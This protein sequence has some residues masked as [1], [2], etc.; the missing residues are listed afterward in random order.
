MTKIKDIVSINSQAVLSNAI[1]L[2]WYN[3]QQQKSENDRLVAGYVFG[4]GI[5]KKVGS[6]TEI[7]SLP[8]FETIRDTFGN[9][10]ASNIITVIAKYG[11]GKSHFALVLA[12][13]FGLPPASPVV[14]EIISHIEICSNK[15]TADQFRHFKNQTQK[16]QLVVTLVGHQFQDLRQGFLQALRRALDANENT[17]QLPIKSVS[18]KAVE[19]LKSLNGENLQ[20]A[21]EFLEEKYQLDV[22][23][24]TAALEKFETGKETVVKELSRELLGIAADFGAEVSLKEIIKNTVDD[25]C[26]G[27]DAPFHKMLILFDELGVY[28]QNWCHNPAAAGG[29]APQEVFEACAD[30]PG[31][32]TFVGFVQRPLATFVQDY[33]PEIQAEFNRWAGRVPSDSE[34][35]LVS[36]LEEV[37]GKLLVKKDGWQRIV[38]DYA[39]RIQE[40]SSIAWETIQN[41]NANWNPTAFYQT[42]GRDCFPLHPLTTGILCNFDFTQGGRTIIGAVNSMLTSAEEKEAGSI[43]GKPYWIRPIELVTEF[44]TNF[45]QEKSR[46]YDLYQYV[47]DNA[48]NN[49]ADL[50]LFDVLKALFIYREGG[51]TKQRKYTHA[52]ILGHLA[53]YT[54]T[55]TQSALERLQKDY[56]A[57][58]Y[59]AQK[60]EYE[61]TGVGSSRIV[62]LDMAR[63]AIVG[64]QIDGLTK[65]LDRLREFD[66]LKSKLK[67]KSIASE[68]K[69]DFAIE[70]DEWYLAPR[71]LDGAKLDAE[72]VR[73][74]CLETINENAARGTVIYLLSANAAELEDARE[75]CEPILRKLREDEFMHPVVIA[76]PNEAASGIE[77]PVLIKDYLI[78]GM[79]NPQKVQFGDSLRAALEHINKDVSDQLIQHIRN[80]EY[81]FP[82]HLRLGNSQRRNLDEIAD[83]LFADAYKFRPPS[84][85]NVMK[86]SGAKG[87]AATADI[88]RQ[89]IVN[90]LKFDGLNA[91]RQNVVKQVLIEGNNRWGI[92]DSNYRIQDPKNLRVVQ[93]WSF[94]R[95]NVSENDWT[96]FAK[97]LQKL[98]LPPF[99]YDEYTATFLIAC[100]IGKHKHELAFKDNRKQTAVFPQ[101]NANQAN[102]T[103]ADLQNNL[104]KS[105]KFIEFLQKNVYVQHSGRA[106]KRRATE[107]LEQIKTVKDFNEGK[108]LFDQAGQILQALADGDELDTQIKE[109]LEELAKTLENS[110]KLEN[111]LEEYKNTALR[112]SDISSLLRINESINA[113]GSK[114]GV[115]A[116]PVF[117]ETLKF[118]NDRIDREANQQ[119]KVGLA[120]IE[121]Y[122]SA[123]G[124]LEKSRKALQQAGRSDLEALFVAALDRVEKD[125]AR[126]QAE[127]NEEP[128]IVQINAIQIGGMTLEYYRNGIRTIEEILAKNPSERVIELARSKQNKIVEQE[129]K[130][131]VWAKNLSTT[132]DSIQ[133]IK[134]GEN[135]RF[136]IARQENLFAETAEAELLKQAADKLAARINEIE[137]QQR[138]EREAEAERRRRLEEQNLRQAVINR[139]SQINDSQQR[140]E[141]LAEL[142][143]LAREGGLT[144]EQ[145]QAVTDILWH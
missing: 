66:E 44:E 96:T 74:L 114:N 123:R 49:D 67:D 126:L 100:W 35:H 82:G 145:T 75:R 98:M 4:S 94:L 26:V 57:V 3:D 1:Q 28:S 7:S 117:V 121:S 76:I 65:T 10:Q 131:Q 64:K 107:Y 19:W 139:F 102:L 61:F 51:L 11:H 86:P 21:D 68:F 144:R 47:V 92:L 111:S 33:S 141:C 109:A 132:V 85:S 137:E 54:E 27:P 25:F 45:I 136:E 41:Y 108:Q 104:D 119:S 84:N 128:L 59:S 29:L 43:N 110:E 18:A 134:T 116:S 120:R 24:L 55:E 5:N 2:A 80:V 72:N 8:M 97:L 127:K 93:A 87:N 118:V 56:D 103:L 95:K 78:N 125:Y 112:T 37:I 73:K 40:E 52:K 106:N 60:G 142:A 81:I 91:E 69:D 113:F 53:G 13:Y 70:G 88:A 124:N 79:S 34:Y 63:N 38:G 89:L 135:L 23:T 20:R 14:G 115:Q 133:D 130:L 31:K 6:H 101:T 62:V 105:K 39:P 15:A 22:D 83:A 143:R 36:N 122:D 32:L 9:P 140:F 77:K 16:A 17:R 58:R 48:L 46:S 30:R 138:L 99:G 90:D 129:R 71:F 12:N 42:V 50:I